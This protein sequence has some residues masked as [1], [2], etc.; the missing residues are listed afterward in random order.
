MKVMLLFTG[1]MDEAPDDPA[2]AAATYQRI[3][4]WWGRHA[5]AGTI[6]GGEQLAGPSTARRVDITPSGPVVTDGPFAEASEV[7]GGFAL[8]EVP[9]IEAAVQL[10]GTWPG[11]GQVEVRPTIDM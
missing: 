3:G 7:V 4:E 5:A 10:A 1:T 2:Q 8:L 11:G 6:V 9:N